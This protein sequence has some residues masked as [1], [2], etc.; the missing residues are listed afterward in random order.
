M[1]ARYLAD[2]NVLVTH[3]GRE[4]VVA[5]VRSIRCE[6]CNV[7][8]HPLD[9]SSVDI[10]K[11]LPHVVVCCG[12]NWLLVTGGM[13]MDVLNAIALVPQ[14]TVTMVMIGITVGTAS[15]IYGFSRAF[16]LG[17]ILITLNSMTH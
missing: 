17:C 7:V 3:R 10:F 15:N 2:G 11:W 1:I 9:R 13:F 14:T 12:C 8:T 4:L 16:L 6:R 5:G